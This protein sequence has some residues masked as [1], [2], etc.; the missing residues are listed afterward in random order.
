[1]LL[2]REYT[3]TVAREHV[4]W[5]GMR[6]GDLK[7]AHSFLWGS[8]STSRISSRPRSPPIRVVDFF[9]DF[10][11]LQ[12]EIGINFNNSLY[13]MTSDHAPESL[14]TESCHHPR[15]AHVKSDRLKPATTYPTFKYLR[16]LHDNSTWS[17]V[18]MCAW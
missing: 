12:E 3:R 18:H 4:C 6:M 5:S 9:L 16:N 8:S 1:M 14:R 13:T 7:N 10:Q 15:V 2:V 11:L 17:S